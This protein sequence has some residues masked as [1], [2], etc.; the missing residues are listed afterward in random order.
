MEAREKKWLARE[1]AELIQRLPDRDARRMR[2]AL[3][4]TDGAQQLID[5]L[6]ALYRLPVEERYT[7]LSRLEQFT[8]FRRSSR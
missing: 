5:L 3:A 6:S 8:Q 2:K 7:V 4:T 1:V